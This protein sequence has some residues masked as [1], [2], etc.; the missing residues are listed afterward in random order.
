MQVIYANILE[1]K[2]IFDNNKD[3]LEQY[4]EELDVKKYTIHWRC[5]SQ[6]ISYREGYVVEL[7]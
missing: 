2:K 1:A 3:L 5:D 6:D 4:A 7:P